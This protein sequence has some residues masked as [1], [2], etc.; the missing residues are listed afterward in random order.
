MTVLPEEAAL[1]ADGEGSLTIAA[2]EEL[3]EGI[4]WQGFDLI[5]AENP[6]S[7]EELASLAPYSAEAVQWPAE[8]AAIDAAGQAVNLPVA[9]WECTSPEGGFDETAEGVY[10]FAP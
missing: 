2:F 8:L 9:G 5:D 6:P 3:A 10:T 7:E 4:A 1:E